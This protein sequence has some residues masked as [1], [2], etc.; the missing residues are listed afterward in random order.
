MRIDTINTRLCQTTT[1]FL[2]FLVR[3]LQYIKQLLPF[4]GIYDGQFTIGTYQDGKLPM[5]MKSDCSAWFFSAL[6]LGA[7]LVW[8]NFVEHCSYT[9][10]EKFS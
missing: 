5:P 7:W 9:S 2:C 1:L 3:W 4:N 6:C 10:L 8:L